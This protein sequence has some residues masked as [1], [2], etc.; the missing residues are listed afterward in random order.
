MFFIILRKIYNTKFVDKNRR[1]NIPGKIDV[2]DN[3]RIIVHCGADKL[4]LLEIQVEGKQR[5]PV[6]D[7]LKGAQINSGD[8]LG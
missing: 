6:T 3:C 7:W 2:I 4:E 5:M 1:S 8:F